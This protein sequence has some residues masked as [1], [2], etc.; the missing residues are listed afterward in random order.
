MTCSSRNHAQ[1]QYRRKSTRTFWCFYIFKCKMHRLI[2]EIHNNQWC[3]PMLFPSPGP[4]CLDHHRLPAHSTCWRH[5][6]HCDGGKLSRLP[7]ETLQLFWWWSLH[8]FPWWCLLYQWARPQFLWSQPHSMPAEKSC[9]FAEL[10]TLLIWGFPKSDKALKPSE[11]MVNAGV[12]RCCVSSV[13]NLVIT[14]A[15]NTGSFPFSII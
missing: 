1:N 13:W 8:L 4:G 3:N 10:S 5:P 6:Q 12:L 15:V 11:L 9:V 14:L 7:S 2:I